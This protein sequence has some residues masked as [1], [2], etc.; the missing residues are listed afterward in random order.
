MTVETSNLYRPVTHMPL[1]LVTKWEDQRSSCPVLAA[2]YVPEM[3]HFRT[4]KSS[5]N[6]VD[7]YGWSLSVWSRC[8]WKA[9][10]ADWL[11]ARGCRLVGPGTSTPSSILP[12]GI[13]A[14]ASVHLLWS[15]EVSKTPP[16]KTIQA[17]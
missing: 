2:L 11:I 3:V 5:F 1:H 13:L 16:F 7:P 17:K 6:R 4:E 12:S 9:R 8:L 10:A 15:R 14:A